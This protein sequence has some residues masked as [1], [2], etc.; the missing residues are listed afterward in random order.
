MI[1]KRPV[2][3][4]LEFINLILTVYHITKQ[5]PTLRIIYIFQHHKS[6]TIFINCVYGYHSIISQYQLHNKLQTES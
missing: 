1:S 6:M 2:P 5:K 4:M 3:L